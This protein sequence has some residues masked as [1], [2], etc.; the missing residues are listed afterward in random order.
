M[1][2]LIKQVEELNKVVS[3]SPRQHSVGLAR[4]QLQRIKQTVE[5]VDKFVMFSAMNYNTGNRKDWQKL[6]ELLEI[7]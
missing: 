2:Q 7:K 6:K 5:A 1:K 4:V 3:I